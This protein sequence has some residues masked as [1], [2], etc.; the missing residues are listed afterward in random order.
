[1]TKFVHMVK[2]KRQMCSNLG[3]LHATRVEITTVPASCIESNGLKASEWC[4]ALLFCVSKSD[5][6]YDVVEFV[7]VH[8][9]LAHR[10]DHLRQDIDIA[11]STISDS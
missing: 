4:E 11:C 8:F 1:M 9:Y 6:V 3:N 2:S 5:G 7:L 10:T